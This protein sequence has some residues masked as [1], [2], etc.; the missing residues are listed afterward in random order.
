[1]TAAQARARFADARVARLA[2]ADVAG[3]PHLVP[4]V[5]APVGDDGLCFA[6]DGK[7]KSGAPLRRLANIAANPAVS[8]LVDHY[9]DDWERLWWARADGTA[10]VIEAGSARA[11]GPLAALARR[12]P[13]YQLTAPPGPVVVISVRRWSGWSA[14]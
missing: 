2:T 7:P 11:A 1:M 8:V 4:I 6:V 13:Q 9:D 14:A 5:F 3:R 12:Y 10:R